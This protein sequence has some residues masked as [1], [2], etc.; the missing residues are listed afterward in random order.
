[1]MTATQKEQQA[2]RTVNVVE[3]VGGIKMDVQ[4]SCSLT[5]LAPLIDRAFMSPGVAC[6]VLKIN[7]PGG[8][9]TQCSLI[10]TRVRTLATLT[11][12]PVY[13]VI[14]DLAT[15]GAYWVALAGDQ[16]YCDPTSRIGSF[17]IISSRFDFSRLLDVF[18][19]KKVVSSTAP[20]KSSNDPYVPF[21]E[22]QRAMLADIH[23]DIEEQFQSVIIERRGSLLKEAEAR[24]FFDGRI[25]TGRQAL[26]MGLV[27]GTGD[28]RVF[29]HKHVQWPFSTSLI[30]ADPARSDV[31][32]S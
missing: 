11:G 31:S 30:R 9:V 20:L 25:W 1:M 22:E 32:T 12:I 15:S 4:D 18:G 26:A 17:G 29:L 8:S 16:I 21:T 28:A 2:P 19:V 13:S 7:S 23:A 5:T 10:Y 27:D 24:S 6:V 14:E 3:V